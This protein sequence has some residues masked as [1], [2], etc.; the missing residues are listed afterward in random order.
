[1]TG[2]IL[3]TMT[4]MPRSLKELSALTV[5]IRNESDIIWQ[6]VWKPRFDDCQSVEQYESVLKELRKEADVMWVDDLP[7]VMS[8]SIIFAWDGLKRRM[9]G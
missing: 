2:H 9:K 8:V 5:D 3:D 7:G 1:M 4:N 6:K